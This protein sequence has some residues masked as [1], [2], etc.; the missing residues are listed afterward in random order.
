MVE[1]EVWLEDTK[2]HKL[3][4]RVRE[5]KCRLCK[6]CD[7][8]HK[9]LKEPQENLKTWYDQKAGEGMLNVGDRV[10]VLLP[11]PSEPLRAKFCGPY[12]TYIT[13]H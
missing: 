4:D 7:L 8:F 9:D 1:K 6:I 3:L 10:L 12:I 2:L 13:T 5:L 11:I